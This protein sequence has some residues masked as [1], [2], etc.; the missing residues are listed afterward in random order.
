MFR[1]VDSTIIGILIDFDLAEDITKKTDSMFDR[2]GIPLYMAIDLLGDGPTPHFARHDLESMLWVTVWFAYR[3]ENGQEIRPSTSTRPPLDHWLTN[4][5]VL[6]GLKLGFLTQPDGRPTLPFQSLYST[7]IKLLALLFRD[8]IG[9]L[10]NYLDELNN[11]RQ[12]A[13]Q[14]PK[15]VFGPDQVFYDDTT[16]WTAFWGIL[17]P[18]NPVDY[19]DACN[20]ARLGFIPV[21][22]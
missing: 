4:S 5:Q 2:T 9:A 11:F 18:N 21:E 19:D 12:A 16:A 17:S 20:S 10:D 3:Y 15:P 7:W 13:H 22:A 6:Q 14:G 8:G 1:R